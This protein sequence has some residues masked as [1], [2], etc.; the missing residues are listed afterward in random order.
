MAV[1]V[2]KRLLS[3]FILCL[4]LD[5]VCAQI[6]LDNHID[7]AYHKVVD[8][9]SYGYRQMLTEQ[10]A[11]SKLPGNYIYI[12]SE[13]DT[14]NKNDFIDT[15]KHT[16]LISETNSEMVKIADSNGTDVLVKRSEL[17]AES[18]NYTTGFFEAILRGDTLLLETPTVFFIAIIHKVIH[19]NVISTYKESSAN[20]KKYKLTLSQPKSDSLSV[21]I[22]TP[23]F[24]LSTLNFKAGEYIYGEVES[25]TDPYYEYDA[26]FSTKFIY[27]RL[28]CKYVFMAPI[29]DY[30][31]SFYAKYNH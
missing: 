8:R 2:M 22:K 15:G 5:F 26:G 16:K 19:G 1:K 21:P 9:F 20:G 14:L 7:N 17:P 29:I 13:I 10:T 27:K 11:N 6:I 31:D 28:H 18:R 24:K 12:I 3:L 4:S 25:L 30:K 23:E